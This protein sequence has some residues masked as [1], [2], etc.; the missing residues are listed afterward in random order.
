MKRII[1]G[2]LFVLL[3]C[4]SERYTTLS[5]ELLPK[6]L[7]L[8]VRANIKQTVMMIIPDGFT[9]QE[10][11]VN[12]TFFSSG[13]YISPY[14]QFLSCAH[15]VPDGVISS[16]TA[17]TYFGQCYPFEILSVDKSK[18]LLLGRIEGPIL[19]DYAT[20]VSSGDLEVGE[21][22]IGIGNPEALGFS[23]THGIVSATHRTIDAIQDMTQSD[24]FI[25]P[26]NSGGGLF[27]LKGELVG[28]NEGFI[29]PIGES[30]F[31][32]LGFSV[33]PG[34]IHAFLDKFKGL[35]E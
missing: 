35:E 33:S 4:T 32:G 13:V 25:N 14:G 6:T 15:I 16:M 11:T 7:C 1:L 17:C 10:S 3:G 31:T 23:V 5:K 26:G 8:E 27:N 30:V 21:E 20:L 19:T 22:V 9:V 2:C 18:D 24:T 29:H 12:A 28:I 34:E